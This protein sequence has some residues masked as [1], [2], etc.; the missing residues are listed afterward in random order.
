MK[1][2]KPI[3]KAG[4]RIGFF[5]CVARP[6]RRGRATA[7]GRGRRVLFPILFALF[8]LAGCFLLDRLLPPPSFEDTPAHTQT[9]L[10]R[11]GSVLRAFPDDRRVWRY[12]VSLEE[13]SPL[14]LEAMLRYEDRF[15][16]RHPGVNPV[17][18]VRA[19]WQWLSN[20]RI[21]SGGSTITMQ[22]AR[23]LEP[24]PRTLGGKL[25]QSVRALQLELRHSKKAIL[26]YYINH[27]PM[28][29]V[30]EGV[31]AASRGYFGKASLDLSHAEAVLLAV[32]PQSPSRLRPDRHPERAQQARDKV[33]DRLQGQW[34]AAIL[35]EARQEPVYALDL[36]SPHLAPLLAER[37]RRVEPRAGRIH[38]TIDAQMQATVEQ[39]VLDRIQQLPPRV[40][41]A[42]LVMDNHNAEVRAYAGSADFSDSAR[43]SHVD[44]VRALR[45]PGS[46]LKPFLYGM[47]LDEGL[48][49]SESLLTDVPRSFAGYQ[50][51]NFQQSFNGAVSVS[52]ALT[53]SLNVP[54]VEVLEQLGPLRF[55]AQLRQGGLQLALPDGAEPNLALILGGAATSLEQLVGAY[56]ALAC[57]GLA[58]RP[59][60]TP[61]VPLQKRRMLSEGAAFIIRDILESGGAMEQRLGTRAG[62]R[63]GVAWKTGTSFGF[64]DAWSIGVSDHYSIGVWVGR[65]DGTPNPG[66]FG[67][68]V[69]APLLLDL[70][71]A[72]DP[73][74]PTPR[75]PPA[76][77][78]R[79][80]I[81]WPLGL[82]PSGPDDPN[83]L[84][85]RSAWLLHRTTPPT[86]AD[87]V[88]RDPLQRSYFTDQSRTV[89]LHPD[90]S[91]GRALVLVQGVRWPSLLEPW[92]TPEQRR[93]S[94]PPP[95]AA[96][97][98]GAKGPSHRLTIA[99][100][101]DGAVLRRAADGSA[102]V[103]ELR[104]H[105]AERELFWIVNGSLAAR[106]KPGAGYSHCFTEKG[107]HALT[108]L[109]GQGAYDR[110]TVEVR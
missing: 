75:Q 102:P 14:Y 67:A 20:G 94:Q 95:W 32:L 109:D 12:P 24:Y 80:E 71:R 5:S 69:A 84:E 4:F 16:Y 85:R 64:R 54:A 47:A 35:R 57:G 44:M 59:R 90:C 56:S 55:A 107:E 63:Q 30:L 81:C 62:A 58:L 27:V 50:P 72:L 45:S 83:C 53:K 70:F 22:V 110:I 61:E 40:S 9:V 43:F 74:P 89:R 36:R 7:A 39:L 98:G 104:A 93:R 11:D 78:S 2:S 1:Q 6:V 34:P 66:F 73:G 15:F 52:E 17:A 31:E 46:T 21:V 51:G 108:V 68:N 96:A 10:A 101:R 87:P 13:V 97:C 37:L 99:G 106:T 79:A 105:G 88:S 3:R 86:F 42:V 103:V 33:L 26:T 23:L 8:A 18:F 91:Q 82:R 77:V 48:I 29:G 92:L 28:G 65:P 49:H 38:T 25:R 19:G 100:L 76:T 41:M 60:Y